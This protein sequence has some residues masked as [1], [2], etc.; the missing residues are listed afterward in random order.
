MTEK[1]T[2]LFNLIPIA[3][4]TGLAA[5]VWWPVIQP[6]PSDNFTCRFE[7]D[8]TENRF[9]F[10][11]LKRP[12]K[13]ISLTGYID[14]PFDEVLYDFAGH[15]VVEVGSEKIAASARG[16]VFIDS[17]GEPVGVLLILENRRF[18]QDW[19]DIS[20]LNQDGVADYSQSQA[21]L[22]SDQARGDP[23]RLTYPVVMN[24]DAKLKARPL[25]TQEHAI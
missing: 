14:D 24:C 9:S 3:F 17:K 15:A 19:L 2:R 22:Y 10:G 8:S 21:F 13:R 5:Y 1:M 4:L 20:T 11:A 18:G 25:P 12:I 16:S 23:F 7:A 6:K